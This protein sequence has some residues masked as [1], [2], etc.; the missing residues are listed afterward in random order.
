MWTSSRYILRVFQGGKTAVEKEGE[1][2]GNSGKKSF[3]KDTVPKTK[4]PPPLCSTE[5]EVILGEKGKVVQSERGSG[6]GKRLK[7]EGKR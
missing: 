7:E 3:R 1:A 2:L 6:K 4:T 5:E